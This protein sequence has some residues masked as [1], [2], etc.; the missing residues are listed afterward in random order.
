MN[1]LLSGSVS[2]AYGRD[3]KSADAAKDAFLG[4][5]NFELNSLHGGGGRYC[6]VEDF[7][8][9]GTVS[10]RYAKLTKQ[11]IVTVPKEDV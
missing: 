2:P 9:G 3:Y 10:V 4:G 5:K 6:S 11:V 7:Q 8:P 1:K